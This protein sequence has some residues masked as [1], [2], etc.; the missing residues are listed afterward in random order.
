[1]PPG[2]RDGARGTTLLALPVA[3]RGVFFA[4]FF[5]AG[6]VVFGLEGQPLRSLLKFSPA[7]GPS[8]YSCFI[9][10]SLTFQI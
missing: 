9:P 5:L 1:M 8:W 10:I 3:L 6:A 7:F 4:G 2:G